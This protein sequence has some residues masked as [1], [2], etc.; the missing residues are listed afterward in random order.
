[1][2]GRQAREG[3]GGAEEGW[4]EKAWSL[5]EGPSAPWSEDCSLPPREAHEK[6]RE[7]LSQEGSPL[8]SGLPHWLLKSSISPPPLSI[9]APFLVGNRVREAQRPP[10]E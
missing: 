5:W 9:S 7:I 2:V 4:G 3:V 6:N 1:M 8:L 10:L